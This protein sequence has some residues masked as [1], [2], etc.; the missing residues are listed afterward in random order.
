MIKLKSIHTVLFIS[1]LIWGCGTDNSSKIT[2]Q[3]PNILLVV[4]D[5]LGYT[6]LGSFGGEI[7]TP[8]LDALAVVGIRNTAFYTAPTCSPT[9]AMLLL[10]DSI[11]VDPMGAS[12]ILH[13]VGQ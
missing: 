9:R 3:K 11:W 5:D 1:M 13:S 10:S 4:A 12:F 7:R 6:D 2:L 8:N